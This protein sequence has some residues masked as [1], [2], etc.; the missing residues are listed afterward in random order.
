MGFDC[1]DFIITFLQHMRIKKSVGHDDM[2]W[3]Q[4]H[5]GWNPD[6][7]NHVWKNKLVSMIGRS[8][9]LGVKLQ[10]LCLNGKGKFGVVVIFSLKNWGFE[11]SG[12]CCTQ[13]RVFSIFPISF[14]LDHYK[15]PVSFHKIPSIQFF[16][17][18]KQSRQSTENY[19]VTW[20]HKDL[21]MPF[22]PWHHS[23]NFIV[24][25]LTTLLKHSL[26]CRWVITK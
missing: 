20:R 19:W 5:E 17:M 11:K 14:F 2:L 21:V 9:E 15:L 8:E 13:T 24:P 7:L 10:S 22:W 23:S 4:T 25:M 18:W 3:K 16:P 12:F 1:T 6:F 26:N